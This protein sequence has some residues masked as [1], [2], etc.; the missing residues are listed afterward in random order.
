MQ[1]D[2][3]PARL[4]ELLALKQSGAGDAEIRERLDKLIDAHPEQQILRYI[5]IRLLLLSDDTGERD[6][7]QARQQVNELVQEAYIPPHVELQ[8][9]VAAALGHYQQAA[10]L[11][12]QV[13]PGLLWL[14]KDSYQQGKQ[15]LAAYQ[16]RELPEQVWYRDDRLLVSPT[17][18][19]RALFR[20]YPSAVPY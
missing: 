9:R 5:R 2:I 16:R 15:V 4:Y 10:E 11:Q 20:E 6:L 1:P 12:Q 8:A 3:P 7:E 13:L 18:D 14:G 17:T 19:V